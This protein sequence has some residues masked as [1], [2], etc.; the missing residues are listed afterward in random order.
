M[1]RANIHILFWPDPQILVHF[2]P[3][4]KK[5]HKATSTHSLRVFFHQSQLSAA[6]FLLSFPSS[7]CG[8]LNFLSKVQGNTESKMHIPKAIQERGNKRRNTRSKSKNFSTCLLDH[9]PCIPPIASQFSIL[10][11]VVLRENPTSAQ[12]R[13]GG[14]GWDWPH[15]SL[16]QTT[17]Q[18][19]HLRRSLFP[20]LILWVA[21]LPS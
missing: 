17:A 1:L 2:L 12:G 9:L 21:L 10:K 18:F 5:L 15:P 13:A 7:L 11:P 6:S 8:P 19:Y 20:L 16:L 14:A 3:R 4:W